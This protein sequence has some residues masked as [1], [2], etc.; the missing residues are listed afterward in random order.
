MENLSKRDHEAWQEA[1]PGW[2][3]RL[4]E[5]DQW[6]NFGQRR[7]PWPHGLRLFRRQVF[8]EAL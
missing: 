1:A 4:A 3:D 5:Y 8:A 2:D 7:Q 6:L